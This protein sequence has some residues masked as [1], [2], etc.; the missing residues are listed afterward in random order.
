MVEVEAG[1]DPL[2]RWRDPFIVAAGLLLAAAALLEW[3]H[4]R[5]IRRTTA[6]PAA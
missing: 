4:L 2:P 1:D 3:R 6:H 5:A